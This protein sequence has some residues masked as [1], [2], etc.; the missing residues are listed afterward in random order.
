MASNSLLAQSAAE[1]DLVIEI[2]GSTPAIPAEPAAP[3]G[4]TRD[5]L[6]IGQEDLPISTVESLVAKGKQVEVLEREYKDRFEQLGNAKAIQALL[7]QV[8]PAGANWL[9]KC[10][11]YVLA[12]EA[13]GKSL[14][15]FE[16][17]VKEQTAIVAFQGP[18]DFSRLNTVNMTD[19]GATNA[20]ATHNLYHWVK[21]Q[22]ELVNTTMQLMGQTISGAT[23]LTQ[24][25]AE[26][27]EA[28]KLFNR[29]VSVDE[30]R[31][32]KEKGVDMVTAYKAGLIKPTNGAAPKVDDKGQVPPGAPSSTAT[33]T[34]D[35]A[36]D[37]GFAELTELVE[38]GW[39]YSDATL[40]KALLD[41]F[42]LDK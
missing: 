19:E 6:R 13:A 14:S 42:N 10:L 30:I 20:E 33:K 36:K 15:P 34:L 32:S 9:S 22:L 23:Q 1:T 3:D 11:D 17:Y 31:Q 37:Y 28:T 21:S 18:P 38:K 41:S 8:S 5:I 12:T 35:P 7:E 27:A 29:P 24:E 39:R 40:N 16:D 26:A 2:P 25:Q 4:T